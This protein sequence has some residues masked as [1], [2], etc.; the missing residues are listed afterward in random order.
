MQI[1]ARRER[2]VVYHRPAVNKPENLESLVREALNFCRR[3]QSRERWMRVLFIFDPQATWAWLSLPQGLRTDLENRADAVAFPRR[4][5]PVGVRQRLAQHDKMHSDEICQQVLRATGG[6]YY[7]LENLFARC[8]KQDDP[9]PSAQGIEGEL[10]DP[11]SQL[12]QQFFRSLGLEVS[13]TV[14]RVLDFVL[15]EPEN[16]VSADFVIMPELVEGEPAL[17][18]EECVRAIE[19]LQRMGCVDL[20]GDMLFVDTVVGRVM[21]QP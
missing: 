10:A 17:T 13:N 8:G 12:R 3:H 2:H 14:Y 20:H 21:S 15:Q 6:W 11:D 9:R 19:Y 4:W 7:L 18:P 1:Y 16:E 5:N